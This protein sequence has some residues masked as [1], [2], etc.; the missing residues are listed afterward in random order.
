[1]FIVLSFSFIVLQFCWVWVY[2]KLNLKAIEF[3]APCTS[4][5][6]WIYI[7]IYI[8]IYIHDIEALFISCACC[9][10]HVQECA[11]YTVRVPFILRPEPQ[12]P[13]SC[14]NT[15]WMALVSRRSDEGGTD[16]AREL[17]LQ[18]LKIAAGRHSTVAWLEPQIN[19]R[20]E[21]W[22]RCLFYCIH[23][24]YA[25]NGAMGVF[26]PHSRKSQIYARWNLRFMCRLRQTARAE[27]EV[28]V[29]RLNY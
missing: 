24:K 3:E 15:N 16:T 18:L 1:M 13:H 9:H 22:A 6:T 11:R 10:F 7:Y 23:G 2:V 21:L 12:T 19:T 4:K 14:Y 29:L 28:G 25:M 26:S 20:D 8:Y 27:P 17:Q 5:L